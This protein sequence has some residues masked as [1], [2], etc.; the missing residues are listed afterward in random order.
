MKK[1][2][3]LMLI[4]SVFL[5]VGC[6]EEN[7]VV[8]MPREFLEISKNLGH[9][10]EDYTSSFAYSDASYLIST[11]NFYVLYVKGKKK[12]DVE[13][14][15]LDECKNIYNTAQEGYKEKTGGSD[16]WLS[17]EVKDSKNYYYAVYVEDTYINIKT[18]IANEDKAKELIEKIGY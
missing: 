3:V 11:N 10:V 9:S 17:L 13:G 16:N 6:G 8:F 7:K 5:I 4:L 12:H 15:F 2:K 1:I 18:D 14:L